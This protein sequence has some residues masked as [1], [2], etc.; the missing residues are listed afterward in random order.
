MVW[1]QPLPILSIPIRND[2]DIP[3][4]CFLKAGSY[5][6]GSCSCDRKKY[7]GDVVVVVDCC[8]ACCSVMVVVFMLESERG[9]M[10]CGGM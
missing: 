6:L 3:K 7:F 9:L 4:F 1:C 10:R 8:S 2:F 5:A